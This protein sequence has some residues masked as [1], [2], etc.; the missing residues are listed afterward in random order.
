[1]VLQ[2][3]LQIGS[4]VDVLHHQHSTKD[5]KML[6]WLLRLLAVA[7]TLT[8]KFQSGWHPRVC[9]CKPNDKPEQKHSGYG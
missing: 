4:P 1:M 5:F 3:K 7:V 2:A 9:P 6:F 8:Q